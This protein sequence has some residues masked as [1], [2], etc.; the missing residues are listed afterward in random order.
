MHL[1][2]LD[3]LEPRGTFPLD[4]ATHE[5]PGQNSMNTLFHCG[6]P[7]GDQAV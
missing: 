1:Y 2:E 5:G 7:R 3:F 4:A 6:Q